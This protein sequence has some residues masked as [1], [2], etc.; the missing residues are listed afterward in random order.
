[1]STYLASFWGCRQQRCQ[2]SV[3]MV[4][5]NLEASHSNGRHSIRRCFAWL[6][7]PIQRKPMFLLAMGGG[8]G[9]GAAPVIGKICKK[10]GV[11]TVGLVSKP[12]TFEGAQRHSVAEDGIAE[13]INSVD[14]LIIVPNDGI[15]AQAGE[16]L[17]VASAFELIE[18]T[19]ALGIGAIGDVVPGP[20]VINLAFDDLKA[21]LTGAG[22]A[23]VSVGVGRGQSRAVDAARTAIASPLLE[24][25]IE[26]AKG[27]L[28]SITGGSNLTLFEVNKAAEIIGKAVDPQANIIFSVIFNPKMKDEIRIVLIATTSS[29]DESH[30]IKADVADR[31]LAQVF[32]EETLDVPSDLP[33]FLRRY[34]SQKEARPY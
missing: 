6:A 27:V 20:G 17:D 26:K 16:K 2:N 32:S 33:A 1:M 19:L 3:R 30:T 34:R 5:F 18:E 13:L 31:I 9:T 10:L 7:L 4:S 23:S 25:S 8:T 11:L 24:N 14:T 28:F 15:L 21:V 22:P 29:M 12:F